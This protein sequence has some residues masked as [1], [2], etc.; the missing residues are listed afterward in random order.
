[1]RRAVPGLDAGCCNISC[2]SA[3]ET[4]RSHQGWRLNDGY[5]PCAACCVLYR[6][7]TYGKRQPTRATNQGPPTGPY[8]GSFRHQPLLLT[9][10]L[11]AGDLIGEGPSLREL[12]YLYVHLSRVSGP[13]CPH[14]LRSISQ[15]EGPWPPGKVQ[16]HIANTANTANGKLATLCCYTRS[17]IVS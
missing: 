6:S 15:P 13:P 12:F 14:R 1:M 9:A 17:C 7:A 5:V 8:L 10:R 2:R 3:N 4:I 11:F 16:S